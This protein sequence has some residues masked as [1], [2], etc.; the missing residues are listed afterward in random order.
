LGVA[1]LVP[2]RGLPSDAA[3]GVTKCS[4]E[5]NDPD[6]PYAGGSVTITIS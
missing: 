6:G 2:D 3:S 5:L 1:G 4:W